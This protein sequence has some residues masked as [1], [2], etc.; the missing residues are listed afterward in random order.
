MLW[1]LDWRIQTQC[2]IFLSCAVLCSQ[3]QPDSKQLC[4]LFQNFP[5]EVAGGQQVFIPPIPW[6]SWGRHPSAI[7]WESSR[8]FFRSSSA[9]TA[10]VGQ[11]L[12]WYQQQK[13]SGTTILI[14]SSYIVSG[15]K[16]QSYSNNAF[17]LFLCR[18]EGELVGMPRRLLPFVFNTFLKS[19]LPNR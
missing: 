18:T 12:F 1:V 6:R 9:R 7:S 2:V 15:V 17:S 13:T 3:P 19:N 11:A 5:L 10:D 14:P 4:S 8:A 16:L